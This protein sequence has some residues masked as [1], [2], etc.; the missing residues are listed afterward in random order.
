M[1]GEA[2]ALT[3]FAVPLGAAIGSFLNV[4]IHRLPLGQSLSRPRS[5]CP[6]CETQIRAID[7]VP[8]LSWL[9]LRGRCRSCGERI[10]ARYP[11]VELRQRPLSASQDS[12]GTLSMA[13]I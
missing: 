12:R 1:T 9:A 5:R 3:I 13:R 7:N 11:L 2:A 10:S 4:V 8:M 6:G